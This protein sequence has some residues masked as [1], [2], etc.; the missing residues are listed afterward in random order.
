MAQN[1]VGSRIIEREK[2]KA[3]ARRQV[4]FN[5]DSIINYDGN[6]ALASIKANFVNHREARVQRDYW[7]LIIFHG[8][9]V[10]EFTSAILASEISPEHEDASLSLSLSFNNRIY[11]IISEKF[12]H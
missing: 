1:P 3:R 12:I 2:Q 5:E 8:Y 7:L 10:F 6:S 11:E 4:T 9:R